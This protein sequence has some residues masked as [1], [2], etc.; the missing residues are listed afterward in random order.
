[1]LQKELWNLFGKRIKSENMTNT[2]TTKPRINK[3]DNLKGLAIILI[4]L[5]H[6]LFLTKYTSIILLKNFIFVF[7]LPIFFFVAGYFSKIDSDEPKKAIKRL[8]IPYLLF[9]IIYKIFLYLIIGETSG[10][11]FLAPEHTLW[12]LI[13]LF[14]MK[15]FL[16]LLNKLKYPVITITVLA[17]LIGFIPLNIGYLGVSRTVAF[18]PIFLV[19]FKYKDYKKIFNY[20]YPKLKEILNNSKISIL[21]LIIALIICVLIAYTVPL[22]V[23]ELKTCYKFESIVGVILEVI[24]RLIIIVMGIIVTLL[25]NKVMTNK[26]SILTKLGKNSMAIYL[27][28]IYFTIT[29]QKIIIPNTPILSSSGLI[30][31]VFA[32]VSTTIIVLLLS[33]DVVTKYLN[34]FTDEVFDLIISIINK[35]KKNPIEL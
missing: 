21:L 28:H 24:E 16:P 1:M 14:T 26:K 23:I 34:K 31:L 18:L 25:L 27:L 22:S 3:F 19:G 29:I 15:I 35:F 7:H 30:F 6:M 5:G 33:R 13:S 32:F 2:T 8:L 12:F 4:V 9:C 17:L 10:I 11:I 20:K